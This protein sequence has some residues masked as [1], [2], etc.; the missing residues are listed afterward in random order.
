[1]RKGA[2]LALV[3]CIGAIW[4]PPLAPPPSFTPA[5]RGWVTIASQVLRRHGSGREPT[6]TIGVGKALGSSEL[7][8]TKPSGKAWG[9]ASTAATAAT[10]SE[11]TPN[12]TSSAAAV[13]ASAASAAVPAS[14]AAPASAV[15]RAELY[16]RPRDPAALAALA[17][18]VSDPGAPLYHRFLSVAEFAARFG[19]SESAI[20]ALD[21]YLQ[22]NRL[23]VGP[24]APNHLFQ[25][26]K[27]TAARFEV[28][29]GA[30]LLSLEAVPRTAQAEQ[31]SGA[32]AQAEQHSGALAQAERS[33]ALAQAERSGALAQAE[34]RRG[35]R[36]TAKAGDLRPLVWGSSPRLPAN[37]AGAVAFLDGFGPGADLRDDLVRFPT[38]TLGLGG[39]A[40]KAAAAQPVGV[41]A[42]MA[43]AGMSPPELAAAYGFQ[44]FYAKGD[45]GQGQ[46]IG[47]IEYALADIPAISV[48]QSCVGSSLSVSYDPTA[49]PPKQADSEVA[50]DVEVVAALAPRANVVVYESDQSGTGLAPWELAV[51]GAGPGGLP[52]VISS[53]W[54]AC[55]PDTGLGE[56]YYQT[57]EALFE[58]AAVQGQ[59]VLVASGDDG[60]E[61]CLSEDGSKALAVDDPASAPDVTAVGGTASDTPTGPQYVWN[62]RTGTQR[63]CLGTGCPG[64]GASGGGASDIWPRPSY[65]SP[66]L[67]QSPACLFGNQGCRELPDVSAL[68]GN[69]Y[70]QYCSSAVCGGDSSWVG[71][72]G[73]SLATPSWGTAVLLS[74]GLCTTRIGFLN[75]LLY[76]Q[77]QLLTG[78][79]RSGTNDLTGTH[80]GLYD[81]SPSGGYS[82]AAGLGYLG[83]APPS[84][85]LSSGSLC[86]PGNVAPSY[87]ATQ[88]APPPPTTA[89]TTTTT[90]TPGSPGS[91][92]AA[93]ACT[94]PQDA[95]VPNNAVSIASG[96]HDGCAGYWVVTQLGQVAAFGSVVNYGSARVKQGPAGSPIV[97]IC[98]SPDFLGYWLLAKNGQV[99]AFGDA[100]SFGDPHSLKLKVAAVGMAATPDGQG[101][102]VASR[103]GGVFAFGDAAFYGSMAGKVLERP[104]V[105]IAAAPGGKGYW[106]ASADG[107]VFGFGDATFLGSLGSI[108]EGHLNSPVVGITAAGEGGYR[109]VSAD[110]GVFAFG[111][112]YYGSL[113]AKH[114]LAQVTGAAPSPDGR[115]YY[116]VSSAGQVYAFG[117]APYLG[118]ATT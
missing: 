70:S 7:G 91:Q 54:G 24:L 32:L 13:P 51:S 43:G 79:V 12:L 50:A 3:F 88:P 14:A 18:Q 75:P 30:Q 76:S 93:R 22:A 29:F 64:D 20:H 78:P 53:S 57:E 62:S 35:P 44:G 80:A 58:E 97:A 56:S 105:G 41:C 65:Q 45:Y 86:G 103:D 28:A 47:L 102:W 73:T 59:T 60:S 55:E 4:V 106:L 15:V 39:H 87:S 115:G 9:R 72:G 40:K 38:K 113:P 92:A 95:A 48:F 85:P 108:G 111:T 52:E 99:F 112:A 8:G 82:M 5:H 90:T 89:A 21:A 116:L 66:R 37:L 98:P 67:P 81:A 101:Y 84:S 61:G 94:R 49:S 109:L 117:D 2:R 71:F 27:G 16:F 34:Q 74:E 69:P 1:M 83:G 19:A 110:G 31:H 42:G 114:R 26:V 118:S 10:K 33:G 68:A 63:N 25:M 36:A 100:G 11:T 96:E 77:P 46:T 6:G 17:T 23:Q 104:I 107:G